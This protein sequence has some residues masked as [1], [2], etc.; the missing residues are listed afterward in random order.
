M[1]ISVSGIICENVEHSRV[2]G[3]DVKLDKVATLMRVII[4]IIIISFCLKSGDLEYWD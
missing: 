3:S 4:V 1:V 2:S